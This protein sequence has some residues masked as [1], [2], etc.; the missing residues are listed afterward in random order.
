[1]LDLAP[2]LACLLDPTNA[3]ERAQALL[4]LV[5]PG[6]L[7]VAT[8]ALLTA[9]RAVTPAEARRVTAAFALAFAALTEQA[10]GP[11]LDRPEALLAALP[12]LGTAACEEVWLV[13]ADPGLRLIARELLTR[14]SPA[15][16][17]LGVAEVL[18]R[19]LVAGGR[20][21]YVVHNHPSGDPTPSARDIAFTN[22]LGA[23]ADALGLL[24]HDHV[25]VSGLRWASCTSGRTGCLR[26]VPCPP[27]G[28]RR[29][30][31]PGRAHRQGAQ[32]GAG[33]PAVAT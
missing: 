11:A 4:E 29:A 26:G 14:G 33:R 30:R 28:G 22:R 21:F 10:P 27:P 13:H 16:V 7:R 17:D 9:T 31:T 24:L 15:S 6:R 1:M 25:V 5:P 32:R 2:T 12:E 18:R 19:V 3:L 23:Q 8:G 20:G